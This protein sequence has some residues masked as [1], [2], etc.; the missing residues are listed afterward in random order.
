[1]SKARSQKTLPLMNPRMAVLN[2]GNT[3]T[4]NGAGSYGAGLFCSDNVATI[5]GNIIPPQ[6]CQWIFR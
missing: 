6:L 3:I 2:A 5:E 1:M 4:G